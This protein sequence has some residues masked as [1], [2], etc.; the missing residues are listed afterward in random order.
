MFAIEMVVSLAISTVIGLYAKK[1]I[2]RKLEE[3]KSKAIPLETPDGHKHM[4]I[5]EEGMTSA[6]TVSLD[7]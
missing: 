4:E 2:S 3:H 1:F 6:S 7:A 5:V